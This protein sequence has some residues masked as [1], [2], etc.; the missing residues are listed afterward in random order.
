MKE[1]SFNSQ[2]FLGTKENPPHIYGHSSEGLLYSPFSLVIRELDRL[3]IADF[4]GDPTYNILEIQTVHDA[5]GEG[6]V[7]LLYHKNGKVDV[8]Y[9][10]ISNLY[11][12]M[13][14][15]GSNWEII[16]ETEIE[17]S[18]KISKKGLDAY[19]KMTDT[20]NRVVEFRLKENYQ[21]T[22]LQN[23]LAPLIYGHEDPE[24][25]PFLYIKKVTPA[26]YEG[27]EIR[28]NIDGKELEP[29][30]LPIKIDGER[31]YHARY[32]DDPFIGLWNKNFWGTLKPIE[33]DLIKNNTS[34]FNGITY[35]FIENTGHYEISYIACESDNHK[36]FF[37]FSPPIPDLYCLKEDSRIQ[38]KFA[39]GV[40]ENNG[41]MG[42]E[43]TVQRNMDKISITIHPTEGWQPV[44][45]KLWLTAYNWLADIEIK[46]DEVTME[47]RWI[48]KKGFFRDFFKKN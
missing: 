15:W 17:C 12:D 39:G 14:H 18:V 27:T 20:F 43:Y 32:S 10:N 1:Y 6:V 21:T 37:Q 13:Y 23:L 36:L 47:S 33:T 40:D 16:G 7:V 31:K 44:P 9:S 45:G 11:S 42:G 22:K 34:V 46:N 38:G 8:Y 25:F 28:I 4:K 26:N 30:L 19:M 3:I 24:F 48:I 29:L 41:V 35:T 2:E 5:N